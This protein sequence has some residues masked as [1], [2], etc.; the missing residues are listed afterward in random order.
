MSC[1]AEKATHRVFH[2]ADPS[3]T[4]QDAR[5]GIAVDEHTKRRVSRL[6]YSVFIRE[7]GIPLGDVD[8]E[9]GEQR[10]PL[11]ESSSIW[12]AEERGSIVGT[13]LQT[14]I[15]AHFDLRQVPAAF[16]FDT[17]PRSDSAPLS[18]CSRFAIA[19]DYRGTWVLPSLV[20][21]IYVHGRMQGGRFGF[22]A[23]FPQ[24]IPL[25]ERVGYMRYT[26]SVID[27]KGVGLLIPMVLPGTDH[28]YLR[29]IRSACLP[30]TQY[31]PD[32]PQW[33]AWL[34]EA[35]PLINT[36]YGPE[37]WREAWHAAAAWRLCLPLHVTSDLIAL[38]FVHM[39]SAGTQLHR[40]GDRVT[41]AF[42]ALHGKLGFERSPDAAGLAAACAPDGI[43]L[44]RETI[45]CETDSTVLCIP[46]TAIAR[47]ARRHPE[48]GARLAELMRP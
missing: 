5:I 21:H 10:D 1:P 18:L 40:A 6:R 36:Y 26:R 46:D 47:A 27:V 4:P 39:F 30:A 9:H 16:A 37:P 28:E 29:K 2:L 48:H 13:M 44:A 7:Q 20:R 25:Y 3:W 41:C 11:D 22:M 32:E 17:F 43:D 15:G 31:F 8:D 34:R 45:R 23:T 35:H 33:G 38:S 12:Y 19:P 24:L 42:V 14:I